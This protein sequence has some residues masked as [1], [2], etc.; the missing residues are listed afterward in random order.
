MK[1]QT[2][3]PNQVV[4]IL[5]KANLSELE[6]KIMMKL[7]TST[8]GHWEWDIPVSL[9]T[10]AETTGNSIGDILI[11]FGKLV[12]YNVAEL[13]YCRLNDCKS[14]EDDF[15]P[16]KTV[17]FTINLDWKSW[18]VPINNWRGDIEMNKEVKEMAKQILN[19]V[20]DAE[21]P[22]IE[23]FY[24]NGLLEIEDITE[25]EDGIQFSENLYD[26]EPDYMATEMVI[27]SEELKTYF[28]EI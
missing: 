3:I 27:I 20:I 6:H 28:E 12:K 1:K 5:I 10:I 7:I 23:V 15:D 2:L 18:N 22:N 24:S 17:L 21:N 9:K 8:R 19:E 16:S 11:A 4:D 26:I 13:D 25:P 14:I